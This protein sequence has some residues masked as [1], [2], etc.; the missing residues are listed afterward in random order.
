MMMADD[1]IK[2]GDTVT[3]KSGG[4]LMTV[5]SLRGNY[6]ICVWFVGKT[7]KESKFALVT[8]KKDDGAPV[9]A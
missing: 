8:L 1:P 6:A 2:V 9:I 4:P 3:V 5:K 7:K